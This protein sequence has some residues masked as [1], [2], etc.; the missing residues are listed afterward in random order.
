MPIERKDGGDKN[1][2]PSFDEPTDN[3]AGRREPPLFLCFFGIEQN[4][5]LKNGRGYST[6]RIGFNTGVA[7]KKTGYSLPTAAAGF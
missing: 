5:C 3:G 1:P 2:P 6:M 4:S 7:W